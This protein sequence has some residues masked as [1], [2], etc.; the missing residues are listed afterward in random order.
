M[1]LTAIRSGR[2]PARTARAASASGATVRPSC[3]PRRA[4]AGRR[5]P[6][7]RPASRVHSATWTAKSSRHPPS[8]RCSPNS[9]V[10]S[11]G[12]M[13]QTRDRA[14]RRRGR[15]RPPR[16][17][18][19]RRAGRSA[20]ARGEPCLGGGVARLAQVRRARLGGHAVGRS[21]SAW[22][23]SPRRTS[24]APAARAAARSTSSRADRS[25]GAWVITGRRGASLQDLVAR[26]R[27]SAAGPRPDPGGSSRAGPKVSSRAWFGSR[28]ADVSGAVDRRD[29]RPPPRHRGAPRRHHRRAHGHGRRGAHDADAGVLLRRRPAD[30]HL[31]RHRRQPVHEARWR[32]RPPAARDGQPAAGR[33]G[34]ASGPCRP[35][36]LGRLADQR[37]S[38]P[39]CRS[40]CCSSG[41][42][43]SRS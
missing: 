1:R 43:G 12:S 13:I 37:S 41:R 40:T 28:A 4:R 16:T 17:G 31:E 29:P 9:R 22:R 32:G 36:F 5:R 7:T 34:C 35:A 30:R 14:I 23:R 38:R 20:R 33:C 8:S 15:R 11:S 42:S 25:C 3:A 18:P 39:A 27:P 10:P 26:T 2:A 19:R 21:A 6:R 24:P